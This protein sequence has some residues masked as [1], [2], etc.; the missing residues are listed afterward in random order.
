MLVP[1][2][3][4]AD[5][6][7]LADDPRADRE[8][9]VSDTDIRQGRTMAASTI[10]IA[11]AL[12]ASGA[13]IATGGAALVAIIGAAAAGGGAAAAVE[14]VG[15]W[16]DSE[17]HR[18]LREQAEHGGILLWARL[19]R[20]EQEEKARAILAECG[21]SHIHVHDDDDEPRPQRPPK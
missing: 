13:T 8:A 11:A 1:D 10:G 6:E 7:K 14:A 4:D 19:D 20:P 17:H 15:R 18:F 16:A 3:V 5:T 2:H 21:A 12:L 9:V